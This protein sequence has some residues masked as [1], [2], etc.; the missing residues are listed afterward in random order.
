MNDITPAT[1]ASP[2]TLAAVARVDAI[3]I[4]GER[5]AMAEPLVAVTAIA[6]IGL[7]GDRYGDR[8]PHTY[9]RRRCQV[10]LIEA[11]HLE[12]T[13]ERVA[14]GALPGGVHR[15]NI[16]T[17]GVRLLAFAGHS[18][19]V[20]EALLV[21]DRRRPPCRRLDVLAGRPLGEALGGWGGICTRVVT[22]GVIRVG[23]ANT[24]AAPMTLDDEA[25]TSA[26]G[27]AAWRGA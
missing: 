21:F 16:V 14:G 20:G 15:R 5:S 6:G 7:A 11:E 1:L 8:R 4:I 26:A 18:F 25:G 24:P 9:A 2:A 10:T 13:A 27:E 12:K 22:G 23:D 19:R 3:F 17:R